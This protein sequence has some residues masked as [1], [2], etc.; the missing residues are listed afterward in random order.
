MVVG[1]KKMKINLFDSN[2]GLGGGGEEGRICGK[3]VGG[4]LELDWDS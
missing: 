4:T 1:E 3:L 2:D